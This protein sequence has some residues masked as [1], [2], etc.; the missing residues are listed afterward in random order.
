V[1]SEFTVTVVMS[2][3]KKSP[4]KTVNVEVISDMI[5]KLFKATV[6]NGLRFNV[7]TRKAIS[8]TNMISAYQQS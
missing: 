7:T 8:I 5:S 4:Q 2:K 1:L 6:W 3:M